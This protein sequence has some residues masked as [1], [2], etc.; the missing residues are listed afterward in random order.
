MSETFSFVENQHFFIKKKRFA[1]NIKN[2]YRN[3]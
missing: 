2:I 1:K 3:F